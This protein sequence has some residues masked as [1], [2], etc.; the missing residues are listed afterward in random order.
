MDEISG[1]VQI[2]ITSMTVRPVQ[3]PVPVSS[4]GR[5]HD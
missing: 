5:A 3:I 1:N 2:H 4:V